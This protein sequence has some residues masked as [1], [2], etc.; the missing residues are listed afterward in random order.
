MAPQN[1]RD[2]ALET[3]P[4]KILDLCCGT[5]DLAIDL[6]QLAPSSTSRSRP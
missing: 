6:A 4:V 3:Q 1:R 5:G 2:Y